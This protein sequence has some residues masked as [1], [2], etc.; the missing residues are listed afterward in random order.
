[1]MVLPRLRAQ[2][3]RPAERDTGVRPSAPNVAGRPED[4]W[5]LLWFAL[6][7]QQ[8]WTSLTIVSEGDGALRVARSLVA[9]GNAYHPAPVE[10]IDAT[11]FAPELTPALIT[12]IAEAVAGGTRVVVAA[13]PPRINPASIA[14]AR[15]TSAVLLDVLVGETALPRVRDTIEI[16]GRE[17]FVGSVASHPDGTLKR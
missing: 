2:P 5:A 16:I 14:I 11:G 3:P 13:D 15:A 10:L 12:T 7:R 6:E 1:M 9:A 8:D 17:R 4:A